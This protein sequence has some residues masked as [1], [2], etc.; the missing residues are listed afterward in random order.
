MTSDVQKALET[1]VECLRHNPLGVSELAR[2][3][4]KIEFKIEGEG[5]FQMTIVNGRPRVERGAA[6]KPDPAHVT[7][8]ECN[9]EALLDLL[10]GRRKFTES[11]LAGDVYLEGILRY[12]TWIARLLR[13]GA[14]SGNT[15]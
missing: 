10:E 12:R 15:R 5:R 3:D 7:F 9:G 4:H 11:W 2:Y 8:F 14:D 13:M 6:L 1:W